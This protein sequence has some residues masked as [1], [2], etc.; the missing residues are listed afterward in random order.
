ML[1]NLKIRGY[2]FLSYQEFFRQ[3]TLKKQ[4]RSLALMDTDGTAVEIVSKCPTWFSSL[5]SGATN[6]F[7]SGQGVAGITDLAYPMPNQIF[8]DLFINQLKVGK[9]E[10]THLIP[11]YV[12]WQ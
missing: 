8:G 9:A 2:E 5:V 4:W 1:T 10:N 6:Y 11:S 7:L 12:P 3:R